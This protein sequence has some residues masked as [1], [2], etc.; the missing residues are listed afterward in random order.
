[1][2]CI[3]GP[4]QHG[5]EDQGW[6]AHF[7]RRALDA[8]GVTVYG[9]GMQVRDLLFVEDLV[10]AFEYCRA[11][12][13]VL[14]GR[15]FN[16]GGGSANAVSIM[17]VLGQIEELTGMRTPISFDAWRVGDQRYYVSDTQAFEAATGWQASTTVPQGLSALCQWL[18]RSEQPPQAAIR[19]TPSM[20]THP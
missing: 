14:A 18:R 20:A 6:V 19:S 10:D 3:Y 17:E 12:I 7:M 2:S 13:D 8:R 1:M 15:A 5:N 9:D 4:H 16:M 11:R